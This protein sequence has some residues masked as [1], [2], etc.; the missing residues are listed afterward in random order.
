MRL[1]AVIGGMERG[2][3]LLAVKHTFFTRNEQE[4]KMAK[5][6]QIWL[7]AFVVVIVLFY[8]LNHLVM[9][10]QGLPLNLDLTPAQ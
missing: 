2:V 9:N 5:N 10:V 3:Y 4:K 1:P 6:L 8:G 7:L